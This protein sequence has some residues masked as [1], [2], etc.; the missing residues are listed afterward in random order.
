MGELTRMF[1]GHLCGLATSSIVMDVTILATGCGVGL[2]TKLCRIFESDAGQEERCPHEESRALHQDSPP[3]LVATSA[4][5]SDSKLLAW[6]LGKLGTATGRHG[7]S[8]VSYSSIYSV[9]LRPSIVWLRSAQYV[10]AV[11]LIV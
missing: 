9:S 8:S 5:L 10:Q 7:A 2:Q 4:R 1:S 3:A 6:Q 11:L